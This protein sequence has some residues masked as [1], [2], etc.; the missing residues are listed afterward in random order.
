[1]RLANFIRAN[2]EAISVE[3]EKFAATLLPNEEFSS[4][5]LRDGIAL[6]MREIAK[7]MDHSQSAAQQQEKSEGDQT[8]ARLPSR[9]QGLSPRV[10]LNQREDAKAQRHHAPDHGN[11]LFWLPTKPV[12]DSGLLRCPGVEAV[13]RLRPL[14]SWRVSG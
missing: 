12:G 11:Q 10:K 14:V 13:R 8:H 3:W 5:V 1:M 7:D 4:S 2:V 6:I 9:A